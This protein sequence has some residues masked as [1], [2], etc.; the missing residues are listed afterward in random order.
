MKEVIGRAHLPSCPR[1][2]CRIFG[3]SETLQITIRDTKGCFHL[4]EV[5]PSRVAK[6]VIGPRITR[7]WLEHLD[8]E[9]SDVVDTD[10]TESWVSQDLLETCA[11]VEAVSEL[12][13]CQIGMTA[14]V[15]GDVNALY[16]LECAHRQQLLAARALNERSLFIRGLPFLRTTTTGDVCNDDFVI[17]SVLQFSDVHLVSSSGSVPMPSKCL[18]TRASQAVHSLESFGE[19]AWM[20]FQAHSDSLLNAECRSC[21]SRCCRCCGQ[22]SDAPAAPPERVGIRPR[23]SARGVRQPRRVPHCSRHFASKQTMST[24][25]GSA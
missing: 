7:S 18:Q 15:L 2:R 13:C 23:F 17:L 1:L 11:S 24:E 5:P 10:E 8:D 22:K 9:N 4:Y 21:S 6:Q 14:I 20:A 12:D 25:R 19:D 3:K 16:T